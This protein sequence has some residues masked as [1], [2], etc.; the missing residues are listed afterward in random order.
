MKVLIIDDDQ[1]MCQL[2]KM[3]LT[4]NGHS[5]FAF[6]E[7][8]KGIAHARQDKP[9]L[10]LMDVM[11]PGLSGPEIVQEL[12]SDA[13]LKTVPVVFLTGLVTGN[14][15]SLQDEG[16]Q[17]GGVMYPTLGKPYEIDRLLKVVQQYGK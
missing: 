1:D 11:L 13:Q 7:A 14:E 17:V 12:K 6:C 2:T 4:K 3:A 16:I 9:N 5:V 15:Q 10:I 8:S